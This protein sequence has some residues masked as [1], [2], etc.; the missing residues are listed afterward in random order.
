[1][2]EESNYDKIRQREIQ[3]RFD[4]REDICYTFVSEGF[5]PK[6]NIIGIYEGSK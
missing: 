5:P 2:L 6:Q 4:P 3:S 1:M